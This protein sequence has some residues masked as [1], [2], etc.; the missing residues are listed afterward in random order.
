MKTVFVTGSAGFIGYHLSKLLLA[1]GFR[2]VGYD[3]MT[4]Y[5]DVTL[6]Q[7]RHAMLMQSPNFSMTEALLE[8]QTALEHLLAPLVEVE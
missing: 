7:R 4:N 3:G 5:Y 8:D 1:E 2:V 6:K